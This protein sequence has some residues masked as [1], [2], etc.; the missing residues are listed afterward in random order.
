MNWKTC[1]LEAE[2]RIGKGRD[3]DRSWRRKSVPVSG[4]QKDVLTMFHATCYS[5]LVPR[6]HPGLVCAATFCGVVSQES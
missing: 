3:R 4:M 5:S 1:S 2:A 6:V